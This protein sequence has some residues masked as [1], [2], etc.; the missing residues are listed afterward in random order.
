MKILVTGGTNGMGKGVAKVLAGIDNQI[1][2]VILLCRSKELGEATIRELENATRNKKIS[3]ILCDLAKLTDVRK[4]IDEIQIKHNFIDCIFINAGLGYAA[5][6]V[7]TEDGMDSHFQV[8]YLSQFMLTLNLLNLLE[9]SE[10]GGRVIFNVTRGGKIFWDDIQM[11][12]NWSFENGIHQAMVAKR[13]FLFMLDDLYIRFNGSKVSFIGFEIS[14]T[15]WSNQIN[16]I[17]ASMKIM[18]TIMKF[19]GTF[20]SIE[21]CGLIMAP[22]FT[23]KHEEIRKKS[24]KFI[25]WKN[26]KFIEIKEDKVVLNQE[27][28]DR[29][30]K[31]SLELC[32]DE[33]TVQIAESLYASAK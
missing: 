19:F 8:N 3:I 27:I 12:K 24:G 16:I 31:T 29:L 10:N 32:R 5:Q 15:V 13:M 7:E 21:K 17:P 26:N 28:Q 25:T 2:E 14:K 33:K 23:E 1:H 4:A 20:I 30:W 9:K 6:R 22:L 18:A 11:K